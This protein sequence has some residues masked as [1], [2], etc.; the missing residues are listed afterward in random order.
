[1]VKDS[2]SKGKEDS[3]LHVTPLPF[4]AE[5]GMVQDSV[6]KGKV[7]CFLHVTMYGMKRCVICPG[8]CP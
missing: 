4:L 1:M 5:V 8:V 3:F 2:V 6:S 7:V